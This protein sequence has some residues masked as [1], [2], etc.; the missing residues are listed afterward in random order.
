MLSTQEFSLDLT[1]QDL[2]ALPDVEMMFECED[3]ITPDHLTTMS[4]LL[5]PHDVVANADSEDDL[6]AFE[7]EMTAEQIDAFL[8]G[9]WQP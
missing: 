1:T 3:L 6:Y 5:A 2:L 8:E 9:R 7:I 4:V